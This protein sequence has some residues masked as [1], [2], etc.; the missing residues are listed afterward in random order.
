VWTAFWLGF[1]CLTLSAPALVGARARDFLE[2]WNVILIGAVLVVG[3]AVWA[4]RRDG[5]R[6]GSGVLTE[7][8]APGP[9]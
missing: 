7:V 8:T 4:M 9:I 2:S 5:T 3:V 6:D 1:A